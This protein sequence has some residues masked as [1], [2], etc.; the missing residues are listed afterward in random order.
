ML[1]E[2]KKCYHPGNKQ[3]NN[4]KAIPMMKSNEFFSRRSNEKSPVKQKAMN[5][6]WAPATVRR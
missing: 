4:N 2:K 5:S 6:S 1:G 3:K